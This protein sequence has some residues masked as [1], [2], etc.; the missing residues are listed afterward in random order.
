MSL[1]DDLDKLL[2]AHEK[3]VRL[4]V[5]LSHTPRGTTSWRRQH[6]RVIETMARFDK[7]VEHFKARLK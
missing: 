1:A 4:E 5:D 7:R 3:L 6:E 2:I